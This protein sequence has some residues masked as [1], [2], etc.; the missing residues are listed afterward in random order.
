MTTSV[1]TFWYNY[2]YDDN[3]KDFQCIYH[4]C[5]IDFKA[6]LHLQNTE[7]FIQYENGRL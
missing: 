5:Y 3:N 6:V 2:C 4:Y 1:I 7:Y